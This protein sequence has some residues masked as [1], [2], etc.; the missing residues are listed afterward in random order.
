[1]WFLVM[2]WVANSAI[3]I[4][5]PTVVPFITENACTAAGSAMARDS[6][7]RDYPMTLVYWRCARNNAP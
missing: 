5:A 3:N 6:T 4:Q 7:I 1:M 2:V